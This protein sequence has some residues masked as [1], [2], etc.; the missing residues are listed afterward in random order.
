MMMNKISWMMLDESTIP[1]DLG[2]LS[3]EELDRFQTFRFQKRR[4]DW[5]AGRW[6]AKKLLLA[7]NTNINSLNFFEISIRNQPEG[8]PFPLLRGE[9]LKGCLSISH[10]GGRSVAA[11]TD[12]PGVSIGIDLELIEEKSDGF[13][14]DYFTQSEAERLF[15]YPDDER[16]SLA[17]LLWSGREA[18]LK[19]HQTGLRL[20]TR[21][22]EL[23]CPVWMGKSEWQPI[24]ILQYPATM[25]SMK[26][27]WKYI[28]PFVITMAI[29]HKNQ[30]QQVNSAWFEQVF[31]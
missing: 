24:K 20:D 13:I 26:L 12:N 17:S 19:A 23:Q 14:E 15:S 25:H 2:W 3:S 16:A 31:I 1:Q 27:Y 21:H 11:F 28:H 10:R 30:P 8:A 4:Q 22:I 6:V 9:K 29:Q 18:M 5:L 7:L